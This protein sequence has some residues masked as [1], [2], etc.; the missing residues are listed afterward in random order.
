MRS[1]VPVAILVLSSLLLAG[2]SGGDGDKELRYVCANGTEINADDHP[3][4]N[5]TKAEDL[6]KFCPKTSTTGSKSNTT[7]QAPNVPPV[8]VLN[9]TDGGGNVTNVILLDGNLTFDAT[10]SSD[11]DGSIAGIAVT[12]TDSNTT[13]TATLYDAAKKEFKSATFTFDR[14]GPVNVTVAMVDERAGFTVNQ[15]HVYVNQVVQATAATIQ[16][17]SPGAGFDDCTG[18]QD[19]GPVNGDLYEAQFYKKNSFTVVPGV[20]KIVAVDDADTV[21]TICGPD[22]LAK[23]EPGNPTETFPDAE[24][25]PPSGIAGY[26]VTSYANGPGESTAP[27]VTVHYEPQAAAAA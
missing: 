27:V 14:P 22:D 20:T 5:A 4:A 1:V 7:S 9:I 3:E 26:Y 11:P 6:A 8:L 2:C 19:Q 12:I 21:L 13:K 25:P 18:G 10:G 23:S 16:F 24:L 17:P 15:T